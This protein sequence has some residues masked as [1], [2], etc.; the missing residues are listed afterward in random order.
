ML[1][2]AQSCV[3]GAERMSVT[4]T[5]SLDRDKFKV[6]YYLVGDFEDER[7]PLKQFIPDDLSVRC[8]G[9]CSSIL[10]ILKF[11]FILA[12]EKPDV[13]FSSVL[14]IN[15]KLLVLRKLFRHVKFVIRCDNY[16][17]TYNDI[18]RR[19][20]LKTY[21]NAD[22]IIAQTEEMKQELIDEI[23]IS[24]DKVV[25]LQNPVDTETINKK[26][27]IGKNPYS[28]DDKVRYVAS[29]RFAHQKG[30]DLLVEA[31]AIVKKQ[32]PETE[33]YIVGRNDGGCED[34]YN[35]VKQLIEKHGLQDSVKC[36]GF[37]NNPYVYIKYADCFVLSSRWE[38][39]PNVMIESLYLGTPV[40][41]FKC[42]PVI[43]RIVTDGADG[44]L[45]EKENVESLAKAMMKASELGRVKSVYKSASMDDFHHVLEFATKPG[46][47]L[48][49]KYIIS[50][51]PPISWYL[52]IRKKINDKRLYKLRKQYIPDIRKL[53]TPDT[54]IISSNCFAGRI[55]QDLGMQYNT[56]TLGLYFF[57]DDFIE[58]LSNLKYYLTEAKLEFLDESRYP[59][60]NERRAKWTHWYPI[61]LL[62]GKV[63]IQFLHYH[64][65]KE[66]AEKWYRRAQRVNFDKLMVI[67][68]EQNLCTIDNV[69]AFDK[70]PFEKK[71][72]FSTKNI[73]NVKSNC[74]LNVF[75]A[76]GE[77]GDPYQKGDIFYKELI[78]RFNNES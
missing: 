31:F 34:Y 67:G 39:L 52:D 1:V 3:G 64:T 8:I 57:A 73:P 14:N 59:L 7:A 33:L 74:F 22:I 44:Y 25:A 21:P 76:Q 54:S 5:K 65:A 75:A 42:I 68:M 58:F 4:I 49:L 71:I 53:I 78:N 24:E 11:F 77:V 69:K 46:K 62:G 51:T 37:Q 55:M 28:A 18:Q 63:E 36:V 16:L 9:S 38:G 41:A 61:G 70:L 50:L 26:I 60:G 32:Q 56:P 29:G 20:I 66:A 27:Q 12:K 6:Q 72:F 43:G 15:N 48:R 30:F 23:H 35:E 40:A 17:Y 2:F 45:A 13:V 47:R 10:L 19:I